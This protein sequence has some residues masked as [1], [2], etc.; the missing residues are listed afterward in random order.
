MKYFS[1]Q[2]LLDLVKIILHI[3]MGFL[4][5]II[6]AEPAHIFI[7]N[8][9]VKQSYMNANCRIQKTLLAQCLFYYQNSCILTNF[10]N[11]LQLPGWHVASF[12]KTLLVV[13]ICRLLLFQLWNF[14]MW[15]LV[16]ILKSFW[17]I[18]QLAGQMFY[19]INHDFCE[20]LFKSLLGKFQSPIS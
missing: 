1:N 16:I 4:K 18:T 15:C 17:S 20:N 6:S 3:S 12:L 13:G 9:I 8:T 19:L 10:S 11:P 5:S 2:I 7:K 14:L